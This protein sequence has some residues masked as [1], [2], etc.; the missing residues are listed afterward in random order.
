[1]MSFLEEAQNRAFSSYR[2]TLSPTLDPELASAEQDM[3]APDA[4]TDGMPTAILERFYQSPAPQMNSASLL[5]MSGLGTLDPRGNE[6]SNFSD[7]GFSS[8]PLGATSSQHATNETD[9]NDFARF[10]SDNL[11]PGLASHEDT[12]QST[13]ANILHFSSHDGTSMV[14]SQRRDCEQALADMTPSGNDSLI[15]GDAFM[16]APPFRGENS[17]DNFNNEDVD[18]INWDVLLD[19]GA[20]AGSA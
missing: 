9:I 17:T 1:M 15:Y 5:D 2:A 4:T 12:A 16:Q 13:A 19:M 14:A 6:W 8:N 18:F 11:L 10:S 20:T 7:S 3:R